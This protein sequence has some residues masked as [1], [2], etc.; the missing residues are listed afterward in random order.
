MINNND[1]VKLLKLQES[2]DYHFKDQQLLAEAMTHPSLGK[3][4]N[5]ERLEF[6]G[7]AVLGTAIARLL[8]Q[9]YPDFAEGQLARMRT[10]LVCKQ[11]ICKVA[12]KLPL[13][14]YIYMSQAEEKLGGR[15]NS[16]NIEN[17]MEALIGALFLDGGFEVAA[18]L[19]AKLWDG[20]LQDVSL[21]LPDAKTT[22]QEKLQ[23][24]RLAPPSY[25]IVANTGS[26]HEPIFDV[27]IY[28]PGYARMLGRGS[29]R[30][31][32]EQ[33]AARLFLEQ[34]KARL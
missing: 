1:K 27:C 18:D 33:N 29:S 11:A 7:D 30:K 28:V 20:M 23:A 9:R 34:N 5:Y 31:E 8:I 6:L 4:R 25:E 21:Q 12:G 32:A 13:A 24:K 3:Y 17:A 22:L 14:D 26:S 10:K 2:M 15:V 16:G 19:V